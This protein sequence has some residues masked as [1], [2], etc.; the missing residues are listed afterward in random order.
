MPTARPFF[1][2]NASHYE[3]ES[4]ESSSVPKCCG[5]LSDWR[6]CT[7]DAKGGRVCGEHV[8]QGLWLQAAYVSPEERVAHA[9]GR[10]CSGVTKKN[11]LCTKVIAK[12]PF[13]FCHLHQNQ[14]LPTWTLPSSLPYS[15]DSLHIELRDK[16]L[17]LVCGKEGKPRPDQSSSSSRGARRE[18]EPRQRRYEA[19]AEERYGRDDEECTE[20]ESRYSYQDELEPRRRCQQDRAGRHHR[21]QQQQREDE[22]SSEPD[23]KDF[24]RTDSLLDIKAAYQ[25]CVE[26]LSA[27]ETAIEQPN[28]RHPFTFTDI[29]W[30]TQDSKQTVENVAPEKI[31]AFFIA[32][33]GKVR[34][35]IL[36]KEL[37][38][39]QTLFQHGGLEKSGVYTKLQWAADELEDVKYT[40][41]VVSQT[42]DALMAKV[43]KGEQ[44]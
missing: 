28:P 35:P 21:R 2:S 15:N 25:R 10:R 22:C 43:D 37:K 33:R 27:L 18:G 42:L 26:R 17:V 32:L 30:P 19:A 7:N 3:S 6:Q 9:K 39:A 29:P 14:S 23:S 40:V 11:V 12:D 24:A 36:M 4:E 1:F 38:Q 5:V 8:G 41:G 44:F 20:T 16:F 34:F 31:K 13:K